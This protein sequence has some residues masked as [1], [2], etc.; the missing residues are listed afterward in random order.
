MTRIPGYA[1]P[2]PSSGLP[3][4]DA[5]YEHL[6]FAISK[7]TQKIKS[8]AALSDTELAKFETAVEAIAADAQAA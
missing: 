4:S 7:M 8:G 5:L 6:I 2:P 1:E 3:F